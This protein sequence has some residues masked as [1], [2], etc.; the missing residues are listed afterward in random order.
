M[1]QYRKRKPKNELLQLLKLLAK[2]YNW[3]KENENW[4][5]PIIDRI[6]ENNQ[7]QRLNNYIKNNYVWVYPLPLEEYQKNPNLYSLYP[8]KLVLK[9]S[10]RPIYI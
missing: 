1:R 10:L 3:Y 6:R 4:I 9:S 7:R 8:A 5:D 2:G